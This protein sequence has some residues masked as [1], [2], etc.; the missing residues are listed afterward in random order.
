[1]RDARAGGKAVGII[2]G[3]LEEAEWYIDM[4][5]QYIAYGAEINMIAAKFREVVSDLNGL[6]L[7]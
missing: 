3:D 2:A 7:R 6:L 5:I 4:G 1:M